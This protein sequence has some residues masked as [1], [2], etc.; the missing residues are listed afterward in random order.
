M[1]KGIAFRVS[2]PGFKVKGTYRKRFKDS[3][4]V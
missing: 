1:T 3:Y 2:D 4:Q